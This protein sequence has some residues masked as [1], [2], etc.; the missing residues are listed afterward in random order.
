M[1]FPP[2]SPSKLIELYQEHI[3]FYLIMAHWTCYLTAWLLCY[4]FTCKKHNNSKS[5]HLASHIFFSFFIIIIFFNFCSCPQ[6]LILSTVELTV[7]FAILN[8][9][10]AQ[11]ITLQCVQ[12]NTACVSPVSE[13]VWV[14]PRL[15]R[16]SLA[17][18]CPRYEVTCVPFQIHIL[19]VQARKFLNLP[20]LCP[21]CTA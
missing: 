20:F 10:V 11:T 13:S 19:Y 6:F 16:F 2:V 18:C 15:C 8:R 3:R 17:C 1:L 9:I 4:C 7:D 12:H 5:I 21:F 14:L